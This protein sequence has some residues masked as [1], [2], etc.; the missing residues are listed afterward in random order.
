MD[1][2]ISL[3]LALLC[4]G[5]IYLIVTGV[6]SSLDARQYVINV[7]MYILL[8]IVMVGLTWAGLD[9]YDEN[10]YNNSMKHIALVVVFFV[11]F[12]TIAL[13]PTNYYLLNHV[14]WGLF[15]VSTGFMTYLTYKNNVAGGNMTSV[16]LSLLAIIASMSYIAYSQ[17]LDS[18]KSWEKPLS[19]SLCALITV[20]ILDLI[21]IHSSTEDLT[22]RVKIYSWIG[23][24]IFSLLMITGTQRIIKNADEATSRCLSKP[25]Y[26]CVDYPKDSLQTILNIANLFNMASGIRR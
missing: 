19:Y 22:R 16:L 2:K 10:F 15:V 25:Q 7:Y 26:E 9:Y 11:S 20:E 18:F 24:I 4:L 21:F 23:L 5:I 3:I 8:A 12:I 1:N 14:A 13:S 6:N 17:P